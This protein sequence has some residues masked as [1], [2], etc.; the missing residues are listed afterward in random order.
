M[1]CP[2]T[3]HVQAHRRPAVFALGPSLGAREDKGRSQASAKTTGLTGRPSDLVASQ[4]P[5]ARHHTGDV[6]GGGA[7]PLRPK[8]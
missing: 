1:C 3:A 2:G 6:S 7:R 8:L 5:I 4:R